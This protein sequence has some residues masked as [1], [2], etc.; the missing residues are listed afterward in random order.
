MKNSIFKSYTKKIIKSEAFVSVMIV[1]VLALGIIGTSFALYMDVDT[2]TDYQLVK[3]GDLAISFLNG[4]NTINLKNMTPT[5]DDIATKS[6]DNVYSFYIYNTGTYI[7]DYDIKLVNDEGNEVDLNY[8]NYQFCINNAKNCEDIR[9]LSDVSD[10]IIY[11]DSL[12]AKNEDNKENPSSYYFLRIW[13]NNK[14]PISNESKNIRLKVVVEAKNAN[15]NLI[16]NNT[17]AGALINSNTISS[18]LKSYDTPSNGL[19]R[20]S[21]NNKVGYYFRGN[22]ENNYINFSNMCFRAVNI[23]GDGEV[24]LALEDKNNTCENSSGDYIIANDVYGYKE[25]KNVIKGDIS[26]T[27]NVLKEFENKLTN[28]DILK[29]GE[30]CYQDNGYIDEVGNTLVD[31]VYSNDNVYYESFINLK[32]KKLVFNNCENKLDGYVSLLTL[33]DAMLA[34][35]TESSSTSYLNGN[36][37]L[38]N[39]SQY[40]ENID[41]VFV[42]NENV[43]S[44][45]NVNELVNYRPVIKVVKG[46]LIQKGDGTKTSPYELK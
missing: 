30:W 27:L 43:I 29:N 35:I 16:N 13:I 36:Y 22:I 41:K 14:Y 10:S 31:D 19:Y 33:K 8:I 9:T 24:L 3:V 2:D 28:K 20:L 25:E 39:K 34:G 46:A 40:S 15:G 17:L 37:V 26:Y 21:E 1:F 12:S 18:E 4:D 5:E 32:N 11:K 45:R 42:V 23:S 38:L 6:A 7:A 44:Y